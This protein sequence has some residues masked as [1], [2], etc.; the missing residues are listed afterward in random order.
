E[1]Y[2]LAGREHRVRVT[3]ASPLSGKT[4]G[5]LRLRDTSGANLV[6]IERDGK[7]LQPTAK[8]ELRAGDVLLADLIAPDTDADALRVKYA[9]E[10]LPLSGMYFSDRTQEIGM[11][12]VILPAASDLIGK[13]VTEARFRDRTGLSVI[14]LRR[15]I[16]ALERGLASETLRLGDTLLVVGP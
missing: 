15:G 13:T 5:E 7:L 2:K 3:A 6:A 16:V 9:L 1:E 4:L 12:E 11:A 8:T 10:A 14:G